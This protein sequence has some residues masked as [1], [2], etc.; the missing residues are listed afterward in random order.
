MH[1]AII[2]DELRSERKVIQYVIYTIGYT[3][4][5]AVHALLA[6]CEVIRY[7]LHTLLVHVYGNTNLPFSTRPEPTVTQ[8]VD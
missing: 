6:S 8:H 2:V 7:K 1:I 3:V 5:C 4:Q